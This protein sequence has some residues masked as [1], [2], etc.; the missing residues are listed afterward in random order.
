ML[1]EVSLSLIDPTKHFFSLGEEHVNEKGEW[2]WW[3]GV[4]LL[5]DPFCKGTNP[6]HEGTTFMA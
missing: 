6:I 1:V 5:W 3:V 4:G 2:E